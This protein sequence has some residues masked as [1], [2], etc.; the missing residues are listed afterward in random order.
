[1]HEPRLGEAISDSAEQVSERYLTLQKQQEE[2][3]TT[4]GEFLKNT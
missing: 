4:G 3:P 1:M 2:M